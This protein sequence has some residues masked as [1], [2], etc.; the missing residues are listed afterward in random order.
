ML[1]GR[2]GANF[3]A[4][5]APADSFAEGIAVGAAAI[6]ACATNAVLATND[7]VSAV[8]R[9]A[10]SARMFL[11]NSLERWLTL[12]RTVE[13]RSVRMVLFL[14]AEPALD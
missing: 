4:T 8:P 14:R 10:R 11:E 6:A 7:S 13:R 9:T 5:I 1:K 2:R 3:F 12:E